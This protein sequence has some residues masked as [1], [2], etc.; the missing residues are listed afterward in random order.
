M[1][2]LLR[3][4]G[5]EGPSVE[6]LMGRRRLLRLPPAFSRGPEGCRI[7]GGT[8]QTFY[9]TNTVYPDIYLLFC[10]FVVFFIKTEKR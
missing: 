2:P 9:H 8:Q 7:T 6:S 10:V 5:P 3:Q 4:E 1:E